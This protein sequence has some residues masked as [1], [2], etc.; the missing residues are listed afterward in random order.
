MVFI[1]SP[2]NFVLEL[3][4]YHLIFSNQLFKVKYI[5]ENKVIHIG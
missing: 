4:T 2:L 3:S 5:K 1:L